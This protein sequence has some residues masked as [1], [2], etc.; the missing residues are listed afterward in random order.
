MKKILFL[1]F[2][3]ILPSLFSLSMNIQKT[4]SDEIVVAGLDRFTTFNLEIKNN[5][6]SDV[7]KFYNLAGYEMQPSETIPIGR[8]QTK[9]I[10][11]KIKPIAKPA[12]RGFYSF[13]YFIK[14]KDSEI[15]EKITFKIIDLKDAFKIGAENLDTEANSLNIYIENKENYNFGEIEVEFESPFFEK[16]ETINL[17]KKEKK[18]FEVT[19]KKEDFEKI[20]AGFYT[21]KAKIKVESL[22]DEVEGIIKFVEKEELEVTEDTK[23]VII[24]T[25]TITKIN[26][27]NV[28]SN[29]STTIKKNIFSRL[30]TSFSPE[31]EVINREGV[32]VYYTWNQKINPGETKTIIIKTNW[33]FPL[34]IIISIVVIIAII[35]KFTQKDL[36][37]KKKIHFVHTK[38]GEFGLKVSIIVHA[39]KYIENVTI[40]DR[41]PPIV[42]LYEKFGL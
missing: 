9:S 26:Y 35:K 22:T 19:L 38:G 4:S 23:G 1:L 16:K 3:L 11:L 40:F 28:V 36:V 42:K 39:K 18:S 14:G 5:G 2:I 13:N 20:T 17:E 34:I 37:L 12:I 8:G 30:F 7:I 32:N 41:L 15:S 33:I 10:E 24:Q 31:P 21:L 29:S 6:D 25:K 27:G